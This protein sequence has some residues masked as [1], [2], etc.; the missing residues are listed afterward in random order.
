MAAPESPER[1]APCASGPCGAPLQVNVI[2]TGGG[3]TLACLRKA[4]RLAEGLDAR[5]RLIVPRTVPYALPLDRPPVA[6]EHEVRRFTALAGSAGVEADV[7]ICYG[8][9]V[10]AI[11]AFVL[12]SNSLVLLGARRRWWPSRAQRCRKR[13][14]S[15]GH[16]VIFLATGGDHA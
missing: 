15:A 13:L 11:L 6:L 8:R 12:H 1:L 3:A 5:I 4:A 2:F 14:E 10:G 7:E 16:R 9:D